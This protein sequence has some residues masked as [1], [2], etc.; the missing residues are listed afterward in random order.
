MFNI[1]NQDLNQELYQKQ[2]ITTWVWVEKV[3]FFPLHESFD[4]LKTPKKN[5][6]FL[7]FLDIQTD[8]SP[9]QQV[10]Q[11]NQAGNHKRSTRIEGFDENNVDLSSQWLRLDNL[12]IPK[13]AFFRYRSIFERLHRSHYKFIFL[14][15]DH[16]HKLRIS[17]SMFTWKFVRL[18]RLHQNPGSRK[19]RKMLLLPITLDLQTFTSQPL[20]IRLSPSRF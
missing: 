18:S 4:S 14:C 15:P 16:N 8:V 6:L 12:W 19:T 5:F 10:F 7:I 3:E 13:C 9:K 11:F 20:H 17:G 2:N 1:V